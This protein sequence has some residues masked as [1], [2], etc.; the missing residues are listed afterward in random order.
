MEP[1]TPHHQNAS[2]NRRDQHAGRREGAASVE[3]NDAHCSKS[4]RRVADRDRDE[5]PGEIPAQAK[6]NYIGGA[7]KSQP[8]KRYR[9]RGED[10]RTRRRSR[11]VLGPRGRSRHRLRG[12]VRAG[13]SM[14]L[15]FAAACSKSMRRSDTSRREFA[16]ASAA[17]RAFARQQPRAMKTDHQGSIGRQAIARRAARRTQARCCSRA[18]R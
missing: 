1:S 10:H 8:R 9:G 3:A 6:A 14:L 13:R 16:L 18:E 11:D 4:E 12:V 5:S 15:T 7:Q 17:R 2:E